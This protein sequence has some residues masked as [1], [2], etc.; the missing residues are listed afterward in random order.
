MT[1]TNRESQFAAELAQA[2][3]RMLVDA[4]I[5]QVLTHDDGTPYLAA[6]TRWPGLPTSPDTC[7]CG[8]VYCSGGPECPDASRLAHGIGEVFLGY[9]LPKGIRYGL[10]GQG[11]QVTWEPGDLRDFRTHVCRHCEAEALLPVSTH[12]L[13]IECGDCGEGDYPYQPTNRAPGAHRA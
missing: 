7:M 6:D 8:E 3:L 12:G 2:A 1:E 10:D 13:D 5:V 9:R 4:D 11:V